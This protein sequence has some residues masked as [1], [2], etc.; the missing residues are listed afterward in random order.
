MKYLE[1]F[2]RGNPSTYYFKSFTLTHFIILAIGLLGLIYLYRNRVYVS[3]KKWIINT[4]I[5]GLL[6]QQVL[7]YGWYAFSGYF[8]IQE[9]LP[10]FNCRIAIIALIVG[11]IFKLDKLKYIGM[12]WGFMGAIIALLTPVLDPFGPDHYSYY[13][14]FIGHLLLLWGSF[15][16][17]VV[18]KK[19]L[20]MGTLKDML[21]FTNVYHLI[22]LIFNTRINS[23]YCYLNK[24]PILKDILGLIPSTIYTMGIFIVF[25]L[26]IVGTH[27]G[28]KK[29]QEKK[30]NA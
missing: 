14:F 25:N 26:A 11:Y 15:Y 19:A 7:L 13:S 8:T 30:V 18:D 4:I 20:T 12:Y 2:F 22:V 6:I 21:L 10:L 24:P 5:Y 17:L 1:R 3:G 16:F 29:F 9:S 28:L 27:W 23:N